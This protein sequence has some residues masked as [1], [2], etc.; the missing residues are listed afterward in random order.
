MQKFKY[1]KINDTTHL[2]LMNGDRE[3]IHVN[4]TYSAGGSWFEKPIDYGKKHLLEHCIVA[5]TKDLNHEEFKDWERKN[6]ISLNAYTSPLRMGLTATGHKSDFELI[7]KT[8]T[9]CAFNPVFDQEDLDREKVIVLREIA[10]RRGDPNYKLYIDTIN[11][12]FLPN[13]YQTHETLGDPKMVEQ[14]TLEDFYRLNRESLSQSHIIISVDGG[15]LDEEKAVEI[16]K[17]EIANSNSID[18]NITKL[19]VNYLPESLFQEFSTKALVHE[20]AHEHAEVTF[21]LP[22]EVNLDNSPA[23]TVYSNLYLYYSG[24]LYDRLRDEKML[25]YGISPYFDFETQTLNINL[26]CEEKFIDQIIEEVEDIFS[27]FEKYFKEEKLKDYLNVVYKKQAMS[28]D[29]LLQA[30]TFSVN[31]YLNYNQIL[32]QEDYIEKI[33]KINIDDIKNLDSQILKGWKNRKTL[34][35]SK[36]EV[37]NRYN[38]D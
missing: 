25:V 11:A 37:V 7:L 9:Q 34:I 28:G 32:N 23:R 1:R 13:T 36:D 18:Q 21:M 6:N 3:T 2:F 33:K 12:T 38:K 8:L 29:N 30:V 24:I 14:T 26:T 10:E 16:I 17:E 4:V 20:L 15:N 35:V 19:P 22:L 31:T 5:R 27:N